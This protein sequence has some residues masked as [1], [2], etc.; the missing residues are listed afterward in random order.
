LAGIPSQ[1][2]RSHRR[3]GLFHNAD[4]GASNA[5]CLFVI[6][7][8]RRRILHFNITR[9]PTSDWVLQQMREAF[10]EARPYRY[11][12]LDRDSKFDSDVMHSSRVRRSLRR[13][14]SA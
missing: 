11:I 6:E 13:G 9:H 5:Y 14:V 8:G 3:H 4:G 10:L 12:I 1:P 2:S 7:N